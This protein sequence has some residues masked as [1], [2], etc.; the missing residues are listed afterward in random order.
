MQREVTEFENE[1]HLA[2]PVWIFIFICGQWH[3]FT[4]QGTSYNLL[5]AQ[6]LVKHYVEIKQRTGNLEGSLNSLQNSPIVTIT[7]RTA[8]QP[9]N[10]TREP[11]Q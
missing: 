9:D 8:S 6:G 11:I 3:C 2:N 7:Q 4:N 5:C 10:I 1:Y